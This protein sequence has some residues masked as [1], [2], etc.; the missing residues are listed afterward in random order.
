[1]TGLSA[2]GGTACVACVLK[3]WPEAFCLF[4]KYGV[5]SPRLSIRDTHTHTRAQTQQASHN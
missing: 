1:M 2:V 5:I 3:G 4:K